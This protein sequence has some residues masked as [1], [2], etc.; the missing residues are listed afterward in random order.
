VS[1]AERIAEVR[2]RMVQ[3][4]ARAGRS[5]AEVTLVAVVKH[6][7]LQAVVDA[8]DAGI[9]DLGDN[10]AQSLVTL[11]RALD[12][13]GRRVRWH[14]I[15]RLQRNKINSVLP[16]VR[17]FHTVDRLELADALARRASADGLPVLVQVNI[18]REPQKGGV[19]PDLALAFAG[20]LATRPGLRVRGLMGI[21]PAGADPEPYFVELARLAAALPRPKDTAEKPELSMGM[22]DDLEAAIAHGA[23]LVRVGTAIF[24]ERNL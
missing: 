10:T 2:A 24:G 14:F 3:A 5:P 13:A 9:V 20:L 12:A 7:P 23:T 18:G 17:L 19:D 6:Q 8:V 16:F 15:G 4:A 21:P 11:A 1:V 22:S